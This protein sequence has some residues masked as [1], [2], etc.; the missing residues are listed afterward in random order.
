[1]FLM[2][3]GTA[4][5][6]KQ[7]TYTEVH[8]Y[9]VRND[10]PPHLPCYYDSKQSFDSVFSCAAVMGEDGMPTPIDFNRQSV[11]AIIGGETNRPTE[12]VPVS[13][14]SQADTLRFKY[15]VKEAAPTSY[16]MLPVLLLV[17][18]K[19]SSTPQIKLERQ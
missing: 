19:P 3:C 1:M 4:N 9:F 17:V 11:I 12:Y 5:N 15:K 7:V 18:D 10:A 14:M 8:G 16:T 13:L 2:A 6:A